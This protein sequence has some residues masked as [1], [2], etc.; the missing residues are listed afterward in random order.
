MYKETLQKAIDTLRALTVKRANPQLMYVLGMLETLMSQSTVST[1]ISSPG[2]NLA[3]IQ[4]STD[5]LK[6]P[7]E[8]VEMPPKGATILPNPH[9]KSSSFRP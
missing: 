2:A 1:S 6:K 9:N 3:Q 4:P 8:L 5:Q 7:L